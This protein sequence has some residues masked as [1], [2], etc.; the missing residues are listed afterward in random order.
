ML[1][2]GAPDED[3][4]VGSLCEKI[5]D[6]QVF[7]LLGTFCTAAVLRDAVCEPYP[8]SCCCGGSPSDG[9]LSVALRCSVFDIPSLR[10][11]ADF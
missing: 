10:R 2:P 3:A 8:W 9:L 5:R 6:R 1:M 11:L 4:L 7:E